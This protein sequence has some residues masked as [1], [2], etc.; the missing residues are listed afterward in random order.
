MW[1]K[2]NK[3]KQTKNSLQ[4]N[5]HTRMT[6]RGPEGKEKWRIWHEIKRMWPRGKE[7]HQERLLQTGPMEGIFRNPRPDCGLAQW[8]PQSPESILFPVLLALLWASGRR[9]VR[10]PQMVAGENQRYDICVRQNP[11]FHVGNTVT[12]ESGQPIFLSKEPT[13]KM[14]ALSCVTWA[15]TVPYHLHMEGAG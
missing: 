8:L 6:Q 14:D 5:H 9:P 10:C 12:K 15:C 7:S 2:Q 4:E 11:S 1:S 3:T 13:P